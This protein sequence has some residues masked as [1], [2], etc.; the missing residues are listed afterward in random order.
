M[1]RKTLLLLGMALC[2]LVLAPASAMAAA[3]DCSDA[4]N[5]GSIDNDA[6]TSY[7]FH[8]SDSDNDELTYTVVTG[9][10]HGT[11]GGPTGY[12]SGGHTSYSGVYTPDADYVGSD[13]FTFKANDGSSDSAPHTVSY[14]VTEP[15]APECSQPS[16]KEMRTDTVL[17]LFLATSPNQPGGCTDSPNR[18]M[19]FSRLKYRVIQQPAHGTVT[20]SGEGDFKYKPADGYSGSDSF[21]YVA[22]N[23]G[24]DSNTLT[25]EITASPE[26]NREPACYGDFFSGPVVLRVGAA[27]TLAIGCYDPDN[28][29]ITVE[30]DRT[31]MRGT[32]EEDAD[33]AGSSI[34]PNPVFVRYTAPADA[35]DG[36][37]SFAYSATDDRG[38]HSSGAAVQHVT[39]HAAD[40]NAAPV[41]S[42]PSPYGNSVVGGSSTWVGGNCS[43]PDGDPLT[44]EVTT[45]PGH[46][47]LTKIVNTG[48]FG[49]QTTFKY[50][51]D[52]GFF[53]DDS[54]SYRA[55]DDRG[56]AT[57]AAS[58][59]IKVVH[60]QPPS[61]SSDGDIQ[62]R[63]NGHRRFQLFCFNGNFGP[64]SA[65]NQEPLTYSIVDSPE[66]GT[67]D[68]TGGGTSGRG[69]Y[70]P[71]QGFSGTD[72]YSYKATNSAGDSP[73]YVRNIQVAEDFNRAPY[74]YGSWAPETVRAGGSR[75]VSVQCWDPDDDALNV[76][77]SD[78][79]HGS[80]GAY[81]PPPADQAYG[82]GTVTYTPDPGYEGADT[83]TF[84]AS[85]G[86]EESD[87]ATNRVTVVPVSTN[88]AP[89]CWNGSEVRV[90]AN[91]THKFAAQEI[92][93]WDRDGDPLTY[94]LGDPEH[95]SISGPDAHGTYTYTPS[96]Q[97]ADSFTVTANDGRVDSAGASIDVDVTAPVEVTAEPPTLPSGQPVN[98][99]NYV[100]PN[101][102]SLITVPTGEVDQFPESCMPL[103]VDTTID[104][105]SGGGTVSD[106][107]LVVDPGAGAPAHEF[108]M[109]H[110]DGDHWDAHIDCV[111]AGD[112]T[113]TWTLTEGANAPQQFSKPVGGIVLIDPQGVI[114]DQQVYD[115]E[116]GRGAMPDEARSKAALEGATVVLQRRTSGVWADV[117]SGDPGISP[118]VNPQVTRADGLFRWDVSAGTYRVKVTRPGY[119]PK[120]SAAVSVP[121]PA[122]SVHVGLTRVAGGDDGGG[123]GGGDGGS[124]GNSGNDGGSGAGSG[125]GTPDPG[126]SGPGTPPGPSPGPGVTPPKPKACAGLKGKKRAQCESRQRLKRALAKC[127]K[128]KGKKKATCVKR[129]RARAKCDRLSGRKK[130][131]CVRRANA[132]GHRGRRG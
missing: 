119:G 101:G 80:V 16:A 57:D 31:G 39:V 55:T 48:S 115:D 120:T 62:M 21:Q 83:F 49:S 71:D 51:P 4:G 69:V 53:G 110:G 96:Q 25:Q 74:C 14:N 85:D 52:D 125:S 111:E 126:G 11:L 23:G 67:I 123:D 19:S 60:S 43:D 70:T 42:G 91:Q 64:G 54:F 7:F 2:L 97:G 68:F 59:T 102:K 93:C 99:Q 44:F 10:E 117:S 116:I 50:T 86:L 103:D 104:P 30:F 81:S 41:C 12:T 76:T 113:V 61:C 37:D 84:K 58:G 27:K 77:F 132:I 82:V 100:D 118:N 114:Y 17:Y 8:C 22:Y 36:A 105:G 129:A 45:Q 124:G 73:V 95:G 13:S 72:T 20:G 9:P 106:V 18:G 121:P 56:A 127:S 63:T 89:E 40:Y 112:L 28:D 107:H 130:K 122:T 46:G 15:Q 24:G 87:V 35:G 33:P 32:L 88:H 65:A 6:W 3:P 5:G 128:L 94:D 131:A 78:P 34:V 98:L 79:A 47:T 38:A 92:P 109:T 75:A 29:P 66:H 90:A 1:T 26:Y 108:Q